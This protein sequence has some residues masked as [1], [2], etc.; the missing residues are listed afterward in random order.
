MPTYSPSI[1]AES[2]N[3]ILEALGVC[4]L[5]TEQVRN[6]ISRYPKG[7]FQKILETAPHDARARIR[8][9]D[10]VAEVQADQPALMQACLPFDVSATDGPA[11]STD[12]LGQ[13]NAV[14]AALGLRA[15]TG[16]EARLLAER[17]GANPLRRAVSDA[18]SCPAAA[19]LLR[20]C[21][22]SLDAPIPDGKSSAP[23]VAVPHRPRSDRGS[24]TDRRSGIG[25]A[26]TESA[27]QVVLYGRDAAMSW[28]V[29]ALSDQRKQRAGCDQTILIKAAH[30]RDTRDCRNGVAWS[31]GVSMALSRHDVTLVA[32]VLLGFLDDVSIEGSGQ[33]SGK[34]LEVV[35]PGRSRSGSGVQVSVGETETRRIITVSVSPEDVAPLLSLLLRVCAHQLGMDHHLALL[36]PTIRA[37]ARLCRAAKYSQQNVTHGILPADSTTASAVPNPPSS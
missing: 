32:A 31:A 28:T 10:I 34:H 4:A 20:R 26:R 13:I 11:P 21:V 17:Y 8:L 12:R 25:T 6:A 1:N 24:R 2:V 15:V 18:R 35:R 7:F 9:R 22:M 16:V 14:L 29:T 19:A 36:L 27:E 3:Q 33:R 30:A 37:A 5:S 23:K